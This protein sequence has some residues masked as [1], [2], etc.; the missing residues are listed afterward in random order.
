MQQ[1]K[2][3]DPEAIWVVND[4]GWYLNDYA[5]ASGIRTLNSTNIYPNI[6]M[7]EKILEDKAEEKRKI[8]NRYSHV[9]FEITNEESDIKLIHADNVSIKLNY[10]DLEKLNIQYILY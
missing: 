3:E 2:T 9:M 6:E 5:V 4:G 10:N 8:Y 7:Y 1:I